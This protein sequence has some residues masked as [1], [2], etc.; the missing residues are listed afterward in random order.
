MAL[1]THTF[2]LFASIC[3][4][5]LNHLLSF[6][7]QKRTGAGKVIKIDDRRS[8]AQ[9]KKTNEKAVINFSLPQL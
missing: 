9:Q 8:S 4:I 5:K 3:V 2:R 7:I 6:V 1:Y